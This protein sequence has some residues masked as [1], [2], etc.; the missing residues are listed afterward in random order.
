MKKPLICNISK[1]PPYISGP[2]SEAVNQAKALYEITGYK[3]HQVTYNPTLYNGQAKDDD[4]FKLK[5]KSE[6]FLYVHRIN[7]SAQADSKVFDGELIKAFIGRVINLIQNK[8]VNVLSTYYLDPH[9]YIAN[10]A[11]LYA[12]KILNKEVITAHKAIGSDILNSIANHL[13]DG[14][15][16]FLLLQL[17]EADL[18]FAVS[19]FAKDKIIELSKII[20]PAESVERI[21]SNMQ[22][23]YAPLDNEFLK[24]KNPEAI[25]NF[26]KEF[27]INPNSK[28]ISYFGRVFPEKGVNDLIKAYGMIKKTF[29]EVCLVIGGDGVELDNLKN[30][31]SDLK[32]TDIIFTGAILDP[33]KKRALMQSSILGVIPTK[34]TPNFVETLCISALE[35]QA[36]GTVLLTTKVGGV[37]EAAGEHSLYAKHSDPRD[38]AKKIA[39]VLNGEVNRSEI[40]KKGF[41][42]TNKFNYLKI[43]RKFLEMVAQKREAKKPVPLSIEPE[44]WLTPNLIKPYGR[45]YKV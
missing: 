37:P 10:Q 42:H 45:R 40:I 34:P 28:I 6:E 15:G 29:P 27:K 2:S 18:M 12:K 32:L 30:L 14:Q 19:Q 11:K 4:Y 39:M 26:K 36:S 31:A 16:K 7:P 35:Y 44:F 13:D 1:Y 5:E 3:H 8:R 41:E 43:T 9:A 33:Q 21:T 20:L 38:L 17:L 23:L 25:K 24:L 22:V